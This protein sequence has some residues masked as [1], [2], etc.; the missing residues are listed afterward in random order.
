MPV[1]FSRRFRMRLWS[2]Q[3]NVVDMSQ[4]Q[5]SVTRGSSAAVS[6]SERTRSMTLLLPAHCTTLRTREVC[7]SVLHYHLIGT[8]FQRDDVLSCCEVTVRRY[9]EGCKWLEGCI[10]KASFQFLWSQTAPGSFCNARAR[11]ALLCS[12][13]ATPMPSAGTSVLMV[14]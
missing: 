2:T 7:M 3:S 11:S 10:M 6:A 12:A 8:R 1:F 5:S 14:F 9:G 13:L 4:R